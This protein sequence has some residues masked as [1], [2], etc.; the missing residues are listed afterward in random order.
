MRKIINLPLPGDERTVEKFLFFPL[1]LRV[2]PYSDTF[3][4]R[5]WER[6][7]IRQRLYLEGYG[8][9]LKWENIHWEV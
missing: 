4:K 9:G 2:A 7:R 8:E 5:W 3:E 1:T 6:S